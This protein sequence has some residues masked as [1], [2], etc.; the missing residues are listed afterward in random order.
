[1]IFSQQFD[2]LYMLVGA[3]GLALIFLAVIALFMAVKSFIYF[4]L[5]GHDFHKAAKTLAQSPEKRD[6][7]LRH[8]AKNPIISIIDDVIKTHGQ[9]SNDLKAEV[10]Y[11]FHRHFSKA[12]RDLTIIRLIALVSPMLGLL[13]TLLGL[14]GVFQALADTAAASTSTVLAAGIWEAVLTTIMGLCLAIPCLIS[15]H[16]LG[17]RLRSFHLV[18]IE[19]GYRFLEC[20]PSCRAPRQPKINKNELS[21]LSDMGHGLVV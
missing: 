10:A 2:R 3:S 16:I 15:Y 18:S 14:L 13:G 21:D 20:Q 9:H 19:Y 8:F 17:L 1:M 4:G 6:S 5:V 12:Q 11:L 7:I